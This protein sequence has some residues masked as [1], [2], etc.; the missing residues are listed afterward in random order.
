MISKEKE[1]DANPESKEASFYTIELNKE[2]ERFLNNRIKTSKYSLC[3]FLPKNV[4]LQFSKLANLYFLVSLF[5]RMSY[6]VQDLG[7][8]VNDP[9]Y[10]I[11][12]G[13]AYLIPA[14][15]PDCQ[16]LHDQRCL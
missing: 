6:I 4:L 8:F 9:R 7:V 12:K 14:S 15:F 2:D 1:D 5:I 10:Y 11:N 3:N 16:Y 13:V